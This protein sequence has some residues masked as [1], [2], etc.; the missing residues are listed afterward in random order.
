MVTVRYLSHLTSPSPT[1]D[2]KVSTGGTSFIYPSNPTTSYR[3]SG[4]I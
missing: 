4:G 1:A 3:Y 2:P